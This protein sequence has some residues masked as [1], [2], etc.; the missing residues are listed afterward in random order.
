MNT[1]EY[2]KYYR[3][4]NG[5][6]QEE[7]A[8][9]LYVTRQAVSKWE[10]GESYPELENII[11]LSD[12]YDISIDQLVRGAQYLKK[13]FKIGERNPKLFIL[14]TLGIGILYA[15]TFGGYIAPWYSIGVFVFMTLMLFSMGKQG[16]IVINKNNLTIIEYKSFLEKLKSTFS[17][18][19]YSQTYRYD[20]VIKVKIVYA[21]YHRIS[22]MD[23]KPNLFQFQVFTSDGRIFKQDMDSYVT[24]HLPIICDFLVKK[25]I[26][27]EDSNNIIQLIVLGENIYDAMH[28]ESR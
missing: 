21:A 4:L 19:R 6:T 26:D 27:V 24:E 2:L 5:F 11:L 3:E 17:S 23:L 8:D 25:D 7:I 18:S 12:L 22:P 28:P 13:P 15:I 20:D 1:H 14:G 10:R 9:K 16:G